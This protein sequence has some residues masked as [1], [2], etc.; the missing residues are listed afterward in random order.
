MALVLIN[1]NVTELTITPFLE[2][3]L[4]PDDYLDW[5]LI[6][7]NNLIKIENKIQAQQEEITTTRLSVNSSLT[8]FQADITEINSAVENEAIAR[9]AAD[10]AII[11]NLNVVRFTNVSLGTTEVALNHS[12]GNYIQV[13]V[14][15]ETTG[16]DVT[17][18]YDTF[19]RHLSVDEV[20]IK[21]GVSGMYTIICI[22]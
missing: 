8:Q 6:T 21:V 4:M 10:A 1:T 22:G 17:S 14:I 20:G 16:Y 9:A 5:G 19:V 7:N 13:T 3:E 12:R 2:L 11:D 15:N 18:H